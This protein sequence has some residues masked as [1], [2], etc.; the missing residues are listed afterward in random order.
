MEGKVVMKIVAALCSAVIWGS[1]QVINK[2]RFKGLVF[3]AIQ[4]ILVLIELSTGTLNVLAGRAEAA[5][6]NCG[7]FTKGLWG[8]VT[9]GEIPRPD[10]SVLVYDHS[11]ILMVT[12]LL[13][14]VILLLFGMVWIW[15]IRDAYR[16]RAQIEKGNIVSSASYIKNLWENSFEYIMVMPGAIVVLFISLIPVLFTLLLTFTNYNQ[17]TMPPKQLLDW[18]GFKTFADLFKIPIWGYT[19]ASVLVWTAVWAFAATFLAYG[20]GLLQAVLINAKGIRFKAAWRAI[21]IL[22][23][24]VPALVSLLVFKVMFNREGAFNELLL[25]AGIIKQAIPFLSNAGWARTIVILTGTWLGFPYFMALISG[26]M[27]SISPELYEAVEID[28]GSG[29]NKF[30]HISL[31]VILTATAPQIVMQITFNFNNFGAI[32]F[33]TGGNPPN[34]NYQFAGATDIL[35]SWIFQLTL[36]NR[37]YNY[38]AAITILIFIVISTF[39]AINL[40]R[41]RV[42]K[43]D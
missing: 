8:L 16:S 24:A 31:P 29:W 13:S 33:L 7:Y 28:G 39:S 35:I 21:Y 23:W 20:L 32:Y 2:Q 43:E 42:Y 5:F 17:G 40:M 30:R 6:R 36:T 19:F 41:S 27:T 15:N 4:C 12:G 34:P 1:G 26:V 14:T 18:T 38:A 11:I 37:M 9:L 22:P 25:S 10:S 3:F